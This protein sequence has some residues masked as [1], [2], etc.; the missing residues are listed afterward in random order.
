MARRVFFSFHYEADSWRAA[1]VRNAGVVEGD[2]PVTD[3]QWESIKRGGDIAIQNWIDRQLSGKSCLIVLIG[4]KTANRKWINYEI[5]KA[6]NDRRGVL[7]IYIHNLEDQNGRTSI[8]GQN[9]FSYITLRDG[10]SLSGIVKDYDPMAWPSAYGD[11]VDN[12]G[13]WVEDAIALRSRY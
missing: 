6:W 11:I 7:G 8:Q 3:N 4:S 10:R 12:I 9:P 2:R 13:D 1:Q 5:V